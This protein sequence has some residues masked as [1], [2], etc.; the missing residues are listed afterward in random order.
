MNVIGSLAENGELFQQLVDLL[1]HPPFRQIVLKLLYQF[2][3]D[4]RCKSLL[5][6][7]PD[8]LVMLLQLIVHFPDVEVGRDL[9]A[10][11]INL[12]LHPRAAELMVVAH[13]T[14][15]KFKNESWILF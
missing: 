6:Y 9:V 12:S 13:L 14:G 10:L 5:T 8:C 11:S 15:T 2:T 7:H 3:R 1:R 4:D